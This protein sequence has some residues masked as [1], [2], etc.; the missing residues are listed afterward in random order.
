MNKVHRFV[1]CGLLF[2]SP[3]AADF[4]PDELPENLAERTQQFLDADTASARAGMARFS[5][6]ELETIVTAFKKSHSKKEQRLFWLSEELY[7]RQAERVAAERIRYLYLAV[8]AALAI[9]LVYSI[10]SFRQSR[11]HSSALPRAQGG[12]APVRVEKIP[13]S[14]APKRGRKKVRSK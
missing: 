5:N 7:R 8:L 6:E 2:F 10:L 11:R 3:L 12:T 14:A 4:D 9:I 1:F 13:P